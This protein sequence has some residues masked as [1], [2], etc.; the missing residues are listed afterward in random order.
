M[1]SLIFSLEATL[2]VFLVM[3][4]GYALKNT[5]LMKE[6]FVSALNKL[7]YNVTLPVLLFTDISGADFYS[8]WANSSRLPTGA[9][10]PSLALPS[11]K[12]FTDTAPSGL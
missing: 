3:I 2:P 10:P 6:E 1:D 11:F 8:V 5:G 9:A 7:N 12:T 4:L